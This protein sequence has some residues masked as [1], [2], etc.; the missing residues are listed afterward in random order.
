MVKKNLEQGRGREADRPG[1]IPRRGW[2][3]ILKRT[4]KE[5]KKDNVSIVSAGVAFY[6]LLA[7]FP[8]IAA[9]VSLYGLV[10]DPATVQEQLAAVQ[11]ILPTEARSMMENQMSRVAAGSGGALGL[12]A[13]FGI[14]FSI[15]SATKGTKAVMTA[16]NIVYG[17]EEGRGFIKQN[18][19]ALT[20][21]VGG[22]LFI[23]LALGLVVAFP[24]LFGNLGLPGFVQT[25]A[26]AL[27]WPV[28]WLALVLGLA[29]LYRYAPDRE[30]PKWRWVNWGSTAASILWIILSLVFSY[31]VANFGNYNETY[32]AIGAVIIL[33]MWFFITSYVVLMGA[34]LNAEMEHQ[35]SRDSTT[36]TP[37]RMGKRGA[38]AAD[39]LGER[40]K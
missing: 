14:L 4:L 40:Q 25:L 9:M 26:S 16:L 38:H 30:E 7:I 29:V 34:E 10:A 32:G 3:D 11:G 15:W 6:A 18:L 27:R 31:Y 22:I 5:S 19:M 21:T 1:T 2:K 28:L 36:G 23:I 17:E 24:A 8:A 20:L 39:T 12:G 33:L 37:R 35:T 13:I